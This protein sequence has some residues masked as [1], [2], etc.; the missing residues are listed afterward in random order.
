MLKASRHDEYC[1][2]DYTLAKQLGVTTVREGLSWHQI[3]TGTGIYDFSRFEPMMKIGQEEGMQQIWDL[4]HFDFPDYLDPFS[5][6]FPKKFGEY[7]KRAIEVIRKYQ[8]GTLYISPINEISFFAWIGA[9]RGVWSPYKKGQHN[10]LAFKQQLVR[11]SLAAM[12]SIWSIDNDVRFIHIDPFMRRVAVEPAHRKVTKSVNEFN[13]LVR[14]EA[15]DMIAGKTYPEVGGEPHY[16]DIVGMN[17]YFHNQEFVFSR[18]KNAVEYAAMEWDSQA[19]IPFWQMIKEVYDRYQRPIVIS[20]TGSVGELRSEWW[21]RT[22]KEVD[23]GITRGLPICGVCAYPTVDRPE[24]VNY[25]LRLSGLWDFK[26]DDP[27]LVR[28]PHE[29]S[30]RVISEYVQAHHSIT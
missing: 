10:G 28:I 12:K 2:M 7:A 20:E 23:E 13:N 11:A 16:L 25:L 26:D 19:R 21:K 1:R 30:L 29:N 6:N 4:N 3:D 9:D 27:D 15:W 24:S 22:L 17:Y 5:E 8:A 18:E 14:F